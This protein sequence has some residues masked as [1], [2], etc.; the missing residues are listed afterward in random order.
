MSG[1]V[2]SLQY[3][4]FNSLMQCLSNVARVQRLLEEHTQMLEEGEGM[5]FHV[6][7]N[8][9]YKINEGNFQHIFSEEIFYAMCNCAISFNQSTS[10]VSDVLC[11]I[12][13]TLCEKSLQDLSFNVMLYQC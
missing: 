4:Y 2:N 6:S 11:G 12:S 3:C 7:I 9:H 5:K 8:I 13:C 1:I 10:I